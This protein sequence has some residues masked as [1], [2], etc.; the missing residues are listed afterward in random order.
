MF[1]KRNIPKENKANEMLKNGTSEDSSIFRL[2]SIKAH[3]IPRFCKQSIFRRVI[4]YKDNDT[5]HKLCLFL[6][7]ENTYSVNPLPD[8]PILGSSNS[9]ANKDIMSKILTNGDTII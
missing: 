5:F 4:K 1:A 9:V 3:L 2:H 7:I 8:M 6:D